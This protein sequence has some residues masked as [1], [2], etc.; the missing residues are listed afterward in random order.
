MEK[1]RYSMIKY[2][3]NKYI[4]NNPTLQKVVEG[5]LQPK[6]AN[7][8]MKRQEL[9]NVTPSRPKEGECVCMLTHRHIYHHHPQ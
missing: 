2:S 9:N 7:Y 3:L 5:K 6:E 1:I 4:S 8:T